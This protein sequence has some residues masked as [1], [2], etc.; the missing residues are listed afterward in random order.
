MGL[1]LGRIIKG[2]MEA[3]GLTYQ[4]TAELTGVTKDYIYKIIQGC[5]NPEETTV[6]KLAEALQLDKKE[7][8]FIHYRDRAPAEAKSY[9]GETVPSFAKMY[10]DLMPSAEYVI[11]DRFSKKYI[12]LAKKIDH[13]AKE[14]IE[15]KIDFRQQF[16]E[17]QNQV[18]H[19]LTRRYRD[20]RAAQKKERLF[21][22]FEKLNKEAEKQRKKEFQ[23]KETIGFELPLLTDENSRDPY[24]LFEKEKKDHSTW[25]L[26]LEKTPATIPFV[27]KIRDDAMT[28]LLKVG[29]IAIGMTGT[30]SLAELFGK[31]V[32]AKVKGLGIIIRHYN[33]QEKKIILTSLNPSFPPIILSSS[34]IE[35]L[36]SIKSAYQDL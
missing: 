22:E 14:S 34:E 31:T 18:A 32:I 8:L 9:F 27:Y 30:E 36:H 24:L 28:P 4:R 7:L 23:K 26:K 20:P 35:W 11:E 12:D 21:T 3:L 19:F 29:D 1:E 6:L 16:Q 33:R 2:R 25:K 17:A 10:R 5:R 15:K 13:Y